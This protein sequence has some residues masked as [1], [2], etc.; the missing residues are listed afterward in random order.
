MDIS[1]MVHIFNIILYNLTVVPYLVC[2]TYTHSHAD[3]RLNFKPIVIDL[4]GYTLI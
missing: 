4:P 2:H 3:E 1:V